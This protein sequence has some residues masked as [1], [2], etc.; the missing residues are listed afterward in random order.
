MSLFGSY[1]TDPRSCGQA[2]GTIGITRVSSTAT[3]LAE[4]VV[5]PAYT[6]A[7]VS[8]FITVG[9]TQ[10]T[11]NINNLFDKRYFQPAAD[12]YVNMAALPGKGREWRLTL[13]HSF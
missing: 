10:L 3:R 5:F 6:L 7:N 8:A 2:G 13:K 1:I 11:A 9:R 12:T 4:P